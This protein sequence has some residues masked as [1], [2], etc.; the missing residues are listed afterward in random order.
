MKNQHGVTL[1]GM[2]MFMLLVIFF[3]YAGARVAPAYIDYWTIQKIMRNVLNQPGL[4]DI[5]ERELRERFAKELRLNNVTV[6]TVDDLEIEQLPGGL[7]LSASFSDK[8]P[9]FGPIS[10]CMDFVAE[11]KSN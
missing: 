7:R 6:V 3:A 5:K 8:K 10:L 9:F 1:G 2:M 4:M 11:A